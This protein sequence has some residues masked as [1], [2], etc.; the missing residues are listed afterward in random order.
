MRPYHTDPIE[1][2]ELSEYICIFD[3][4]DVIPDKKIREA[5]YDILNQVREMD[6][7]TRYTAWSRTTCPATARTRDVSSMRHT[8]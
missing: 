4:I 1:V 7:T 8:P 3:D 5:V 2:K 6:A